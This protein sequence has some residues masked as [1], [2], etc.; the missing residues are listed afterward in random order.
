MAQAA[1]KAGVA[2]MAAVAGALA[3]SVGRELLAF[4]PEV[5]VENGG[6]IFLKLSKPRLVGVYA[7]DSPFTGRIALEV[8]PDETPLGICTSSGKVGHSLSFGQ[9]DAVIALSPSTPLADAVAT[10]VGNLVKEKDD[11]PQAIEFAQGIEGLRGIV[12]L[13][14]DE[15][16][17][18]GEVTLRR[19]TVPAAC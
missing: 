10:A 13:L 18:W 2:P 19:T 3:E 6:D 17:V 12:I 5:I 9:A 14:G 7:A 4:S 8:R 15:L 16:G 1:E 11:I